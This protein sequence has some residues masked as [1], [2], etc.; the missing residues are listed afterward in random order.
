MVLLK[1]IGTGIIS[2]KVQDYCCQ[3]TDDRSSRRGYMAAESY[4]KSAVDDVLPGCRS[5][6]AVIQPVY[7]VY[8]VEDLHVALVNGR[9]ERLDRDEDGGNRKFVV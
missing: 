2:S 6:R 5:V 8:H 7:S 3:N 1:R 4:P 9:R